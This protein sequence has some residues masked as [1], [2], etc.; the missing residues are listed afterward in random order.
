M[1]KVKRKIK[2]K[3]VFI[4]LLFVITIVIL[5]SIVI[6]IPITNIYIKGNT[7]LKDGEIIEISGLS[8]YP[9]VFKTS[10]YKIKRNLVNND[11]I[12]D[13]KI[14][15]KGTKIYIEIVENRN[16]FYDSNKN[17]IVTLDKDINGNIITPYLINYIPD[18]IYDKFKYSMSLLDVNILERISEIEYK[19]NDVDNKRFYLSMSDGNYVY[20]TLDKFKSL[21]N[22]VE[23][24]KKFNNKKGILYLDSGE[25]FEIKSS[26]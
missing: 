10:K 15:K 23:M 13:A 3:N 26:S 20:I 8:D 24:L 14:K 22:Y 2:Y 16:L 21:N 5:I 1:K 12:I 18:T 25:Y 11:Y 6:N 9:S 4:F 7:I 17:M 19:P